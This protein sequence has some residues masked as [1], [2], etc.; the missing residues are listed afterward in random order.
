VRLEDYA[1]I[2]DRG[3]AALIGL[4]GSIDWLCAPRFDSPAVFSAILGDTN[5]GFWRLHAPVPVSVSRRYRDDTLVLETTV[6]TASGRLQVV[7]FMPARRTP[8]PR[9]IR[10]AA[11]LEGTVDVSMSLAARFDYGDVRPWTRRIDDAWTM[12]ATGAALALRSDAAVKQTGADLTASLALS[13]GE[14]RWFE[15]AWYPSYR[16]VPDALDVDAA[17]AETEAWWRSWSSGITYDGPHLREVRRSLFVLKALTYAPS[18]ASVAAVTTSLPEVLGGAKNWDY[19]Y[20]WV[21]DS[22]YTIAA[23]LNAGL[24]DEAR[25][26]RDWVLCALAGQPERMQIMYGVTGARH[27][28][29][30][31]LPQLAGYEGSTPVRIG[32]AAYTQFQLGVYGETM[33]A[34]YLAH[35]CGVEIDASAWA[36]IST[37]LAHVETVWELPDHGIWESRGRPRHYTHSKMQAWRAFDC[38]VRAIDEFGYDGP[39]D[40]WAA[41]RDRIHADVLRNGYDDA[42]GAFTQAYGSSSLDAA[43]LIGPMVGFLPATDPRMVSTV[44]ALERGLIRDGFLFRTTQ[45]PETDASHAQAEGAFLACNFWLCDVY[46]LQG[47]DGDARALFERILAVAGHTGLLAEEYDPSA[48]R[49]VGNLP[50]TLSHA[51]L[52]NSAVMSAA[53]GTPGHRRAAAPPS[54]HV[55][56]R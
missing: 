55:Q 10:I 18:G 48:R 27:I 50:Q 6:V 46:T 9:L 22:T 26:W 4:N 16:P 56:P 47:R 19:R 39:R 40:R 37:L 36:M 30:Y 44:A 15:L 1:L 17:C 29:E 34:I 24:L 33:S 41:I 25:R 20:A 21:R 43:V 53:H 23:L 13:A 45:D 49:L 5:N 7:D 32:N 11:C 12:T 52:V 2:G 35:R 14:R 51:S 42:L 28:D 8:G 31:E 3:T 38:A 54:V